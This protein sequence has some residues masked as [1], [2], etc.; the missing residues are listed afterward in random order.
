M[1]TTYPLLFALA[2]IVFIAPNVQAINGAN[3]GSA[4]LE[5][6][7]SEFTP[8]KGCD[9]FFPKKA[10]PPRPESR[11]EL[12]ATDFRITAISISPAKRVCNINDGKPLSV[13]EETTVSTPLGKFVIRCVAISDTSVTIALPN[14]AR[15]EIP[16]R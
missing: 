14:N 9:P 8:I 5:I 12:R 7:R 11:R 13:G 3:T 1:K 6:K 15:L 10:E 2:V 16:L 4:P